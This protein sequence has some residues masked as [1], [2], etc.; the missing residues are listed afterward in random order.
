MT[1]YANSG[2]LP[3]SIMTVRSIEDLG[4]TVNPAG[5]DP[6]HIFNGN[7]RQ[8]AASSLLTP[9]G[10]AWERSLPVGPFVLPHR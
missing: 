8:G 1:G 6:Y 7:L 2:A 9:L 5:A 4:Y 10:V 3:L